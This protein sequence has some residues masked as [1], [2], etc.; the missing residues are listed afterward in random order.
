[1]SV[2]FIVF[3][4]CCFLNVHLLVGQEDVLLPDS[5]VQE[6]T[7][8]KVENNQENTMMLEAAPEEG[9]K[10]KRQKA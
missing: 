2:K 6:V 4:L 1:M 3:F 7:E 10:K 9:K 5:P 8:Q